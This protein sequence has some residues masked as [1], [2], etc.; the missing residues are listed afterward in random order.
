MFGLTGPD[1]GVA[2][3][4]LLDAPPK[5]LSSGR[6]VFIRKDKIPQMGRSDVG[7]QIGDMVDMMPTRLEMAGQSGRRKRVVQAG[8]TC[9]RS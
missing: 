7:L 8:R 1:V 9:S 6:R 2:F 4:D 5:L 3:N